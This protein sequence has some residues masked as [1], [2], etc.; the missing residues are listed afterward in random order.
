MISVQN[1]MTP[2]QRLMTASPTHSVGAARRVMA[3]HRI[4][5]LPVVD[6]AGLLVGLVSRTDLFAGRDDDPAPL[7]S[8]MTRRV[9]TVDP[10]DDARHAATLMARNQVG[11]LPVVRLRRLVGI[12]TDADLVGTAIALMEQAEFADPEALDE[13]QVEA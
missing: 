2:L 11:C 1:I 8:V 10:R 6:Q 4:R 3:E 12:I 7:E 9:I 13:P 5:H